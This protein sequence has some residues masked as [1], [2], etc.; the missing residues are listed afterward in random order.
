MVKVIKLNQGKEALVDDEDFDLLSQWN[1]GYNANGGHYAS[2]TDRSGERQTTVLMHRFIIGAKRGEIVDHINR[3]RLDNRRSNL[4]LCSAG[5]NA[6]NA[7]KRKDGITS[8]Y[9]GVHFTKR[10][11]KFAAYV[12]VDRDRKFLGYYVNEEDA[13]YY[14]NEH[15]KKYHGNFAVL[16]ELPADFTPSVPFNP[17]RAR[18]NYSQYR[19]VTF[20]KRDKKFI[21]QIQYDKGKRIRIGMFA[22]ER[23]AAEMYNVYALELHGEKAILNVFDEVEGIIE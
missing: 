6:R 9:K 5:E 3:N 4:R 22:T 16:N 10:N 17:D 15:A 19:G 7:K 23:I 1:W 20:D 18:G 8:K 14:Y 21:A 11:G 13:A 12:Q 2:R